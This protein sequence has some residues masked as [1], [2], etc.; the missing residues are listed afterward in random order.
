VAD[1]A[2]ALVARQWRCATAESCTGGG[3]AKALTER[4]GSS[5]WF[6]RG[7][8]TY[9]NEA[10]QEML[11]IPAGTIQRYGAVSEQ[12]ARA[13]AA[14]ALRH[15]RAHVAVAVTGIAGPSGGT[16]DK[17]VGTVVFAWAVRDAESRAETAHIPGDRS[18][19][20]EAS[21]VKAI[22]GLLDRSRRP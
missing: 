7:F 18:A 6:E 1:L 21:I 19:V 14:G 13:M 20:R 15:S 2:D 5:D 4:A 3:I 8:V 11:D 12:T 16:P 10:K 17:P 9:S 22:E